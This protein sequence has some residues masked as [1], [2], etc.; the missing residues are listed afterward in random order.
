MAGEQR[1]SDAGSAVVPEPK[2]RVCWQPRL[3]CGAVF[4]ACA[5][6]PSKGEPER[7]RW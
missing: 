4:R 6:M 7:I 1:E 3:V 2:R 5:V